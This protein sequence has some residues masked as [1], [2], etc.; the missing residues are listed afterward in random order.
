MTR[1]IWYYFT[2][3]DILQLIS[4][5]TNIK[6]LCTRINDK[7]PQR[8]KIRLIS[9]LTDQ[10]NAKILKST[11]SF[12]FP[13]I[14][15]LDIVSF[16][17][18][19]NVC[20]STKLM[21]VLYRSDSLRRSLKELTVE[22]KSDDGLYGMSQLTQLTS[23]DISYSSITDKGLIYISALTN[24]SSLSLRSCETVSSYRLSSP[25][26]NYPMMLLNLLCCNRRPHLL[27]VYAR[28]RIC[29]SNKGISCLSSL[30]HLK[31]LDLSMCYRLSNEGLK[32]LSTMVRL[33]SLDITACHE[34]TNDGLVHLSNL[35]NLTSLS[36][37]QTRV[38][39]EGL[40]HLRSMS[41][42]TYLNLAGCARLTQSDGET[43]ACFSKLSS[44]NLSGCLGVTDSCVLPLTKLNSL[45]VLQLYGCC[46]VT[47]EGLSALSIKSDLR[48]RK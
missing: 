11:I 18:C 17:Y 26:N 37:A 38:S 4:V 15:K 5:D 2:I 9:D 33:T 36:V 16:K 7:F 41:N 45:T 32:R 42:L 13:N 19:D 39:S 8:I 31:S 40:Q 10:Q 44:L 22:V 25:T 48:I 30:T 29:L 28:E 46:N 34:V 12:T 6:S 27:P 43:L 24:L 47:N 14:S 35:I 20:L 21:S 1:E 23:L 3:K